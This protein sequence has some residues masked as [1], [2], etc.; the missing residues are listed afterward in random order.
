MME[1]GH[2]VKIIFDGAGA[3]AAAGGALSNRSFRL[4]GEVRFLS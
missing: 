3:Q 2:E 1:S 4:T